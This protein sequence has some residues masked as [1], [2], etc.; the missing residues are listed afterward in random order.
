M[1]DKA[2]TRRTFL[3]GA[4]LAAA[5]VMI[6]PRHVLGGAG[7]KAPSD[8]LNI[9]GVGVGGMGRNNLRGMQQENIVALCD[10]DDA[11]AAETYNE[12]PAARRYHDYRR[13]LEQQTDID[14]VLVAT[15]DHTHAVIAKAAMALGKHV[16]VQ[17]P[18]V[19]TVYEARVLAQVA[20]ETGVVT[21]MGNQGHSSEDAQ[22]INQWIA[23]GV[24][25]DVRE[26]H[27]WTNRP[28][29]YW[30]QGVERP[31]ETPPVP[32]TMHWDLFLGPAPERP[33]HPAYTP[34]KWRGWVDYGTGALGDMGAHLLDH[35]F[36]ALDLGY[37]TSIQARSTPFNGESYPLATI[38]YYAFPARGDKPP[39]KVTWYDGGLMPP[40][41]DEMDPAET[42]NPGGGVFMVGEKGTLV[43]GEYGR[44]P[45]LIPTSFAESVGLP[46]FDPSPRPPFRRPS[47]DMSEEERE[48]MRRA[49][50]R[51]EINWI[52]ACKGEA[53][54]SCPFSYAAKLTETMLLGIASLKAGGKKLGYDGE[55]MAF[56]NDADANQFLHREYRAGWTL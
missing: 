19:A 55:K 49:R 54:V 56:T 28:N 36:W 31:T 11:Y 5:G 50:A 9:A 45:H 17:K 30:P 22:L 7:F 29:N 40:R 32:D 13:M 16:Y 27:V 33:F 51:H 38:T 23:D 41:P 18:L 53:E 21:Q 14:A 44:S 25:G 20:R 8:T 46:A 47:E 6:V 10:V 24:I 12:Y 1:K 39:V 2:T 15:P 48:A 26:V 42:I 37:P 34:F 3:K 4:S 52:D 43:H 35:P